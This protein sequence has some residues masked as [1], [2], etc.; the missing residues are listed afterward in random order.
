MDIGRFAKTLIWRGCELSI[1][2]CLVHN[3][4]LHNS[5]DYQL[6]KCRVICNPRGYPGRNRSNQD[7]PHENSRFDP[8]KVISV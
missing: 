4:H 7:L 6:G 8:S 1:F 2:P 5:S 3:G